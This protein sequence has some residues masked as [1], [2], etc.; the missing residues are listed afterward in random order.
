MKLPNIVIKTR[1]RFSKKKAKVM[2][3]NYVAV[4]HTKETGRTCTFFGRAD[5]PE[6]WDE[7]INYY[8]DAVLDAAHAK[9]YAL[10]DEY[11]PVKR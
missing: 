4:D 1:R 9:A 7:A 2:T 8:L 3:Y 5:S 10:K 6:V 11:C